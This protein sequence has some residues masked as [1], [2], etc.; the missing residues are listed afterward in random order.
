MGKLTVTLTFLLFSAFASAH[1]GADPLKELNKNKNRL[2][3]VQ[4]EFEQLNKQS[5]QFE[6]LEKQARYL[7]K[8][9]LILRRLM[10]K[11]YPH[12]TASMSKYKLDYMDEIDNGLEGFKQTL[13]QMKT[14]IEN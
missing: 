10:V 4:S 1:S 13:D 3:S 7:Q 5:E 8:N 11:D 12:V 6:S 9:I 14:V 2:S